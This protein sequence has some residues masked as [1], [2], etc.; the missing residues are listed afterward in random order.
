MEI[1]QNLVDWVNL[2]NKLQLTARHKMVVRSTTPETMNDTELRVE[3]ILNIRLQKFTVDKRLDKM[4]VKFI[5]HLSF[6]HRDTY[7]YIVLDLDGNLV[8]FSG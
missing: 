6:E 4:V 2:I 8:S 3:P 5:Y 7:K 1:T